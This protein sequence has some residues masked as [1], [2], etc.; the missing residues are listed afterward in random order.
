[1]QPSRH[2]GRR[3][4]SFCHWGHSEDAVH[5]DRAVQLAEELVSEVPEASRWWF[6]F[7][8]TQARLNREVITRFGRQPHRNEVLG[9][10]ST[11]TEREYL[12]RG[13]MVHSRALPKQVAPAM[14]SQNSASCCR[15]V[16][17]N[18]LPDSGHFAVSRPRARL[19]PWPRRWR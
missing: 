13:Q 18:N 9:R 12:A 7:S 3:R 11:S 16:A 19:R 1:M 4:S 14:R 15:P 6:E 17:P 10:A 2:H 5:L 8:A